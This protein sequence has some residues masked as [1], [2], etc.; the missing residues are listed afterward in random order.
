MTGQGL[1]SKFKR[2]GIWRRLGAL[3][4]DI[5]AIAIV[6]QVCAL[7]LFP[8]TNGRVQFAD[9]VYAISCRK[10]EVIPSGVVVP[11]DLKPNTI[12]DCTHSVFGLP[13]ARM[14]RLAQVTQTGPFTKDIHIDSMLDADGTPIKG[15]SLGIFLLPLLLALRAMFDIRG[16]TPGRRIC[17]IRLAS[18]DGSAARNAAVRRRYGLLLLIAS[19]ALIWPIALSFLDIVALPASLLLGLTLASY[20][21]LLIVGLAAWRQVYVRTDTW[22]DRFAATAVYCL[23]RTPA[24]AG[25]AQ[26]AAEAADAERAGAAV[27]AAAGDEPHLAALPPPL[28]AALAHVQRSYLARHWHGELSLPVSYWVNGMLLGVIATLA[29]AVATAL[30]VQERL[31]AQPLPAL[32]LICAIWLCI[33]LLTLWQTVGIWRSGTRY[34]SVGNGPWGGIAKIMVTLGVASALWQFFTQGLP[35]IAGIAEIVGGDNSLGPHQFRVLGSGEM[36]EFTGGIKFGVAKELEGFLNAMPDVK[37]VRLDSIGGRIREAQIM[38]DLIK[39][40]GLSTLVEKQCLSACTIVFLGGK[41][42]VIL[43]DARLGFHQPSYRGITAAERSRTVAIEKERLQKLGLSLAFAERANTAEPSSM[44]F[45][46]SGELLREH[47]ATRVVSA[48][49]TAAAAPANRVRAIAVDAAAAPNRELPA[50]PVSPGG[51][52][53]SLPRDLVQRL[54]SSKSPSG[55]PSPTTGLK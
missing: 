27:R 13:S 29:I 53:I 55:F 20:C 14:L 48:N 11:A 19:P 17:R 22:Y 39:A 43:S 4:I 26:P 2:A 40:R 25:S 46:D 15:L 10:L 36:L 34:R 33:L 18:S 30:V 52:T 32:I 45:P 42:R 24:S 51:A 6:L 16:G 50:G 31:D 38:S 49:A 8:L 41:D 3:L 35:Q 9:G 37:T 44:W 1:S 12:V 5:M 47:V 21:P 7:V 23:D 28:P 54:Q